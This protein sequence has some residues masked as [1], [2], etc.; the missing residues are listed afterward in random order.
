MNKFEPVYLT[1]SLH[2]YEMNKG[3]RNFTMRGIV[4]IT[5]VN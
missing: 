3:D 5:Q 4:I 2:I 1:P